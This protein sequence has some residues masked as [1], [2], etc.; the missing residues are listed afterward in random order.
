MHLVFTSS[1]FCS[2]MNH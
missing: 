2:I 1:I